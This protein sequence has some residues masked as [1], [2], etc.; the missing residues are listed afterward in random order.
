MT[1]FEQWLLLLRVHWKMLRV[2]T[3][4]TARRSRLMTATIIGFLATYTISSHWLFERGLQYISKL[5]AAGALLSD[6]L[7]YVMFFCFL[8]MLIFSVAVTGYI[9][10][11]RNQDTRWLLTLP[12]SHR[13]VF[14]WKCFESA[15]FSSWGL[16]FILAPLLVAFGGIRDVSPFFFLKV[17]GVLFPFLLLASA[18]G[19]LI[20]ITATRFLTRKQFASGLTVAAAI[21]TVSVVQTALQ[22]REI[23]ENAGLGAALTFQKVLHHTN[24]SINRAMPSTWLAGSIIEWTRPYRSFTSLLYPTLLL[25]NCLMALLLVVAAGRSWFYDSWN[26]SVQQSA[27]SAIRRKNQ[28][29]AS[30]EQI[31][32]DYPQP[33]PLR[34]FTGRPI[35]AISR[36]DVLTF[37]RE[38]AQW[39]QFGLVFGLLAIYASGLRQMNGDLSSPRDLYL[40]AF[41]NLSVCALA[42]STLTTRF[43]FPQFSLEGRRLW[44]LAMSP[45]QM[46]SLILQKFVIS[47]LCSGLMIIVILLIGGYNLQLG[48]QDTLFFA[49]AIGLLTLGLNAL[50]AGLGVLFP[51]LE[52]SNAAKIVSGFGGTLCLVGSFIYILI[53]LLLLAYSRWEIFQLNEID[54]FWLQQPRSQLVLGLLLTLTLAVTILPLLFSRKKLKR[55]EILSNL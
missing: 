13:A 18:L 42:L 7:I 3:A 38:P 55:L 11:Y 27:A 5:P 24:V 15:M 20:L 47:S 8:M 22:D 40:V 4:V 9:S 2:K 32:R 29:T 12:I 16:V 44:I 46:S 41:L 21:L 52:E 37:I 1:T 6:R 23:T 34:L 25:S 31:R 39:V 30:K 19:S 54:P 48:L 33:S 26:R 43:V 50:A 35:A 36:K 28:N 10:L 53:F 14:L 51:N 45:L 49:S 17:I